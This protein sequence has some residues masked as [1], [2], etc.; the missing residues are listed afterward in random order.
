MG[1]VGFLTFGF[2][3]VVCPTPPLSFHVADLNK[4]YI[5]IDGWAYMLASWSDHPPIPGVTSTNSNIM[6]EPVSAGGM[7]AT[8]LFQNVNGA[9][10]DIITPKTGV[11]IGQQGNRLPTYFPCRMFD[12]HSNNV[13]DPSTYAN[14]SGCHLSPTARSMYF[15]FQNDGVPKPQG[16]EF[17]KAGRIYYTWDEV[18]ASDHLVIYNG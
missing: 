9:C 2:T 12:P 6:Y 18:D 1:A 4:G 17:D 10:M 5:S 13:P 14:Y 16:G 7:D 3:E 15:S 11:N 8:F